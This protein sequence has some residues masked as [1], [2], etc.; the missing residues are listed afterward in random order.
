MYNTAVVENVANVIN[1]VAKERGFTREVKPDVISQYSI[2]QLEQ[3]AE[4][5]NCDLNIEFVVRP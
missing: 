3:V 4:T 2:Y 5:L 1:S